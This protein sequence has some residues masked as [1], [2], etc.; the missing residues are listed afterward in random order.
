MLVLS[1]KINERIRIADD[2]EI[3][4]VDIRGGKVR[5][6]IEAPRHVAVYRVELL[7]ER[8]QARGDRREADEDPASP[9][10]GPW[11][12]ASSLTPPPPPRCTGSWES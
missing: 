10:C 8:R 6:G 11:P 9:T 3:T 1:R 7:E 2:V 5:I 12:V 4:V